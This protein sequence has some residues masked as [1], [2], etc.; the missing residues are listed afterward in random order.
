VPTEFQER[1]GFPKLN[2][3]ALD[4]SASEVA[5]QGYQGLMAN[6]RAVLPGLAMK[7]LPAVLRL[8]PRGFL[9][10]AVGKSQLRRT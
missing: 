3:A 4:V 7:V 8:V 6:R 2:S 9:L 5:R 1:A 10:S